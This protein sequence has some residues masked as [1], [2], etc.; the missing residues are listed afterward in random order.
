MHD[1]GYLRRVSERLGIAGTGAIAC[2]LATVAAAAGEVT[3]LARSPRSAKRARGQITALLEKAGAGSPDTV[4]VTTDARDLAD[5]TVV[6][7]AVAEDMDV[8]IALLSEID[9]VTGGRAIL[10]TTT[11]S[12]S[13]EALA[14]GCGAQERFAGLHVFNPVPRMELVEVTF[15]AGASDDTRARTLA[16]CEAIGKQAVVTPDIPGFVVNRLLFPYLFSAVALMQQTGMPARE[17]DRCMTLGLGHPMGPLELLDL[18][19][20]DIAAAIGNAIGHPA[21]EPLAG[22][23]TQGALG[24]KSGRGFHEYE[25]VSPAVAADTQEDDR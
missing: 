12:L 16:L 18:I 11:S 7:E 8:K 19:G 24:R 22:L 20:L 4:L 17:V 25:P 14:A 6:V 10:A 1:D 21:P 3:V 2:G 15:P 5:R 13:V 9:A 23:V